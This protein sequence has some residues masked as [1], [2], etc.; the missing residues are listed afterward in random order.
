MTKLMTIIIAIG[1]PRF[2]GGGVLAEKYGQHGSYLS[3]PGH[4]AP[5]FNAAPAPSPATGATP[6]SF[7]SRPHCAETTTDYSSLHKECSGAVFA[8][9]AMRFT[10]QSWIGEHSIPI[11]FSLMIQF[12]WGFVA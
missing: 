6:G 9:V 10:S 5:R 11:C 4:K 1:R 2:A 3:M 7:N 12:P 8:S